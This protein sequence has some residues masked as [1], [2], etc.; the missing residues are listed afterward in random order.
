MSLNNRKQS[1]MAELEATRSCSPVW[2][3]VELQNNSGKT[4][5]KLDLINLTKTPKDK[6]T[7]RTVGKICD[8]LIAL[9]PP[10]HGVLVL[11]WKRR[12][13]S[14]PFP[15]LNQSEEQ[16][17]FINY[18]VCLTAIWR[19]DICLTKLRSQVGKQKALLK[20]GAMTLQTHRQVGQEIM[21][22]DTQQTNS[23]PDKSGTRL[24]RKLANFK[25]AV[26]TQELRKAQEDQSK[27][28]A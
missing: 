13:S 3:L 6:A 1:K 12:Q 27:T 8:I 16:T 28:Q 23:G 17:L 24:F 19:T 21:S 18:H 4:W 11:V 10:L 2:K 5:K 9:T 22:T 14:N 26:Y 15:L 25:A 20:K 7:F